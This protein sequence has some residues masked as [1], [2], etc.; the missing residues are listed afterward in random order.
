MI[1][2][3][4]SSGENKKDFCFLK[5]SVDKQEKTRTKQEVEQLKQ[6]LEAL[7]KRVS[8]ENLRNDK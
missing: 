8:N 7:R 2:K 3:T 4:F 6:E 5:N 1:S